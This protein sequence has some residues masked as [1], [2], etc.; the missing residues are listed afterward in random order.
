M[1]ENGA[2]TLPFNNLPPEL[3]K[4]S[5]RVSHHAIC[6]LCYACVELFCAGQLSRCDVFSA[7]DLFSHGDVLILILDIISDYFSFDW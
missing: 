1:D 5:Q 3:K 4:Q 6:G 7:C 2:N